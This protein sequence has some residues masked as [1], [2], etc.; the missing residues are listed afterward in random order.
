M[1][2][3]EEHPLCVRKMHVEMIYMKF[4]NPFH[5]EEYNPRNFDDILE[6]NFGKNR[7]EP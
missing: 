7:L 4:W 2:N 6:G 1:I 3:M 5:V